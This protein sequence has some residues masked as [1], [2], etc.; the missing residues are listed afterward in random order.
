MLKNKKVVIF[1]S[2]G[3]LGS[4][5]KQIFKYALTPSRTDGVDFRDGASISMYLKKY[6]P[7]TILNC[8][9]LTDVDFCELNW[10]L[11]YLI[12][13]QAV[14]H[15]SDYVKSNK[16]IKFIHFSTDYTLNNRPINEYGRSKLIGDTYAYETGTVCKL[17]HLYTTQSKNNI[18]MKLLSKLQNNEKILASHDIMIQPTTPSDIVVNI[19]KLLNDEEFNDDC[20]NEYNICSN[21]QVSVY[22]L[23]YTAANFL[24]LDT[25]LIE[26]VFNHDYKF[27]AKRP[28]SSYLKV[29]HLVNIDWRDSL[30]K[31]L[32][33][34]I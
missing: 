25:S 15:I 34:I 13:A 27:I 7:D 19:M 31:E 26:P 33:K 20:I 2:T 18:L 23:I 24:D 30:L 4:K 29:G 9:A 6:E 10:E 5:F 12:N 8:A 11:A 3:Q 14:K 16:N 28:R 22:E 32:E 1:G 21:K 17:S